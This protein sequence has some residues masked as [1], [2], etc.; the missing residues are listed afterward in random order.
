MVP[1]GES[2]AIHANTPE[3]ALL[4]GPCSSGAPFE[5]SLYALEPI[6]ACL[7]IRDEQARLFRVI[8]N[9]EMLSNI[10]W[11]V[12][13][14]LEFAEYAH[15]LPADS[16]WTPWMMT[17]F[18]QERA[19]PCLYHPHT[20]TQAG[21][22]PGMNARIDAFRRAA[23]RLSANE[24]PIS[25]DIDPKLLHT[26]VKRRAA[27]SALQTTASQ[28]IERLNAAGGPDQASLQRLAEQT[29]APIEQLQQ[30]LPVFFREQCETAFFENLNLDGSSDSADHQP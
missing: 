1:T 12:D 29:N 18:L 7:V 23:A 3:H 21:T 16:L 5:Q 8:R 14:A 15:A 27:S 22:S 25:A 6:L 2:L 20:A 17:R 13:R 9:A 28:M 4:A 26:I 11:P 19:I 10:S 30:M 24:E